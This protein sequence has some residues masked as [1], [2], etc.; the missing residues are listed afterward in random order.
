[1]AVHLRRTCGSLLAAV[2][3]HPRLAMA[4]LRHSRI[5]LT[6]KIYVEAPEQA[7]RDTV[8]RL[9]G[10][11]DKADGGRPTRRYDEQK[12]ANTA[13]AEGYCCCT[14]LRKAGSQDGTGH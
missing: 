3:V 6:M 12:S 13:G 5:A 10:W 2:D 4:I 8:G 1:M 14:N 7:T 9:S 11:L